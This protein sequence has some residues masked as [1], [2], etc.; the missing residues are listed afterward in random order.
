[1]R[2]APTPEP[3]TVYSANRERVLQYGK[4][5]FVVERRCPRTMF[6]RRYA[7]CASLEL[8]MGVIRDLR[9]AP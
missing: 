1:M 2:F 5:A 3:V 8:A 4:G 6:M 9:G 7:S